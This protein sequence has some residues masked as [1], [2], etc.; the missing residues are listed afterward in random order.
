MIT[1]INENVNIKCKQKQI[2]VKERNK[3]SFKTTSDVA[4]QFIAWQEKG[5]AWISPPPALFEGNVS[6]T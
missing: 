6:E 4:L 3:M 2:I 1:G 5:Q